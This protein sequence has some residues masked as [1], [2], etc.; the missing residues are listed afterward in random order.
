MI[1]GAHAICA[2]ALTLVLWRALTQVWIDELTGDLVARDVVRWA[3]P[4]FSAAASA[5]AIAVGRLSARPLRFLALD[6]LS[7]AGLLVVLFTLAQGRL[8]RDYIGALYVIALV[9]RL[10]PAASACI[11]ADRPWPYLFA[12]A[13]TAYA[14]LAAWH[15]AASL[16]LGDQVHYLLTAD[17]L[18]R[19]SV[20]ATLD[21]ELFRRL[22]TLTPNDLDIATHALGTAF[23]PR[24]IQGYALPLVILPG[25]LAAGRLGAELVVALVAAAA[26]VMTAL[27]L[28]DTIAS[29][30]LRG[31]VWAMATFLAPAVLLAFHIY[32]NAFGAAA[33]GAA[34]RFGFTAPARRPLLAGV[35]A[36]LTLFLNP[37]DGLVLLILLAALWWVGRSE[38]AR[39]AAGV[40]AVGLV[41]SA[42]NALLYG[43]PLPYAGYL[44]GVGRAQELVGVST[45]SFEFW[46][47]LPAMLFDRTFGVAGVAP[48]LFI[49][50][51]GLPA[52]LRADRRRLAPA[53]IAVGASLVVLSIYRYWEGG[54]APA[55]RYFVDV[56]P[57]L[58]P[59]VAYGLLVIRD[60]W[61]RA[62]A[63]LLVGTSA[64]ATLL[65][66]AAPARAL[67][68]AFQQ[69]LQDAMGHVLGVS[70]IGWLPSFVPTTPDWYVGA[71]LALV[72][73]LAIVGVLAVYGRRRRAATPEP[74]RP[75]PPPDVR[76]DLLAFAGLN[77]LALAITFVA[78]SRPWPATLGDVPVALAS[79]WLPFALVTATALSAAIG[80]QLDPRARRGFLA[81]HFPLYLAVPLTL[82]ALA[83]P[84]VPETA[85]GV[86]YVGIA[87]VLAANAMHALWPASQ[88][89]SDARIAVLVGATLL[90]AALVLLPY[91]R[92]IQP[93][94]SD[95]P[96]YLIVVQSIVLDRD[97]ELANDYA[98]DRYFSF[99]P[100]RLLEIHGIHVG[101][102]IYSIRDMGLPVLAVIP[103]ALAERTGVLALMCLFGGLLAAQLY[104]LLRDLAFDRRVALLAVSVTAFV[105]PLLTYTTQI[106]PELI[107]ALVFVTVARLLRR[108]TAS[109][110][111]ELALASAFVGALPWLAT[112]TWFM[113]AGVGLAV[114][115]AALWPRRDLVRRFAAA[116]LPFAA[117]VL[118]LGYLNWRMFGVFLP[119]A[120]YYLLRG[121]QEVVSFAPHV[122]LAGLFFDRAFGLVPR[123]PIYLLAFLGAAALWRRRRSG[124][125]L[126]AALFAG[127][128]LHLLFIADI[129][130]WYADGSPPSRYLL[131]GLPFLAVAVAGGLETVL[132]SAGRARVPLIAFAA[133]VAWWSAFVTFV[134]AVHPQLRYEYVPLLRSGAVVKLWSELGRLARPDPGILWPSLYPAD[135]ATVLLAVF[136]AAVAA[137]LIAAGLRLR[138]SPPARSADSVARAMATG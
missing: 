129:A 92:A 105:H 106:Y 109:S 43:L 58:A 55:A 62:F 3:V 20:D 45:F 70:P 60:W 56:I 111:R 99:F 96:H 52:A 97:I 67:N 30:R 83:G 110:L 122:G 136:W 1:S 76:R 27:V 48:W 118:L 132:S 5:L 17:R 23:G 19:G 115:Y 31:A 80:S 46:I 123:A 21:V 42:S 47:G 112:R 90:A 127:W 8:D 77:V 12:T 95:E 103:Y 2:A 59:F 9:V 137:A 72:P 28:R 11:D 35:A 40:A 63:A 25:W 33:L 128:A 120:G 16:P 73:A 88:H 4:A 91:D 10:A 15:Q 49:A 81:R 93:L 119:G 86:A 82:L 57:L 113:V 131:A 41:A 78:V 37:R 85:L 108:G 101:P 66:C 138:S 117:L 79:R 107:A 100:E 13:F 14:A 114:A 68:D 65:L 124:G 32:P 116:A 50:V 130:Y 51:A 75:A 7:W 87:A 102:A 69:Q 61:M 84:F 104:L 39:F 36:G 98:G 125:L 22:T 134:F 133:V 54:Y 38:L 121:Q 6:A 126:L 18:A 53:A 29:A 74:D 34:Y 94:A 44:V 64:L 71:Y 24:A 135:A 89:L 26:S